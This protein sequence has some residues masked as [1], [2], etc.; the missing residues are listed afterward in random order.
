MKNGALQKSFTGELT[1]GGK[2]YKIR[3]GKVI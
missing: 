3:E 1:I 2:T